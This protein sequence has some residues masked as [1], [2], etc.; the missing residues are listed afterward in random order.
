MFWLNKDDPNVLFCD[1]RNLSTKLCDGRSFEINPDIICDFTA[2]PF[3]DETFW[4]VVFDPPHLI[5]GGESSWLI[6]KYGK[7]PKE[8]QPV[9]R[10]GFNECWR[11]LKPH[12]TLVFKWNEYNIPLKE[13]IKAIGMK[14]LYAQKQHKQSKTHWMCFYK[15]VQS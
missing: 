14:P 10:Q 8:W 15:E 11:V 5:R 9:I 12:G 13:I 2:L 4:H 7:L 3:Q 1:N 6:K